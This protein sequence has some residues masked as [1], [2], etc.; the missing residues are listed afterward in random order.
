MMLRNGSWMLA[1]ATAFALACGD[2]ASNGN[3]TGNGNANGNGNGNGTGNGDAPVVGEGVATVT[4]DASFEVRGPAAWDRT[5]T[6]LTV[7]GTTYTVWS[8]VVDGEGEAELSVRLVQAYEGDAPRVPDDGTHQLGSSMQ[9]NGVSVTSAAGDFTSFA[10]GTVTVRKDETMSGWSVEVSATRSGPEALEVSAQVEAIPQRGLVRLT[11]NG[12]IAP[13]WDGSGLLNELEPEQGIFSLTFVDTVD[14]DLEVQIELGS[15]MSPYAPTPG[16][17]AAG[18][19]IVDTFRLDGTPVGRIEPS[20][21]ELVITE[22]GE[23]TLSGTFQLTAESEGNAY[24]ITG[25]F[26]RVRYET[27]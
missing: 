14:E 15:T 4:G 18:D 8:I 16:T 9:N 20:S 25:E 6:S 2:D 22:V 23:E 5:S 17:Y 11:L 26:T 12:E 7:S 13:L 24:D 27:I 1:A 19:A 10:E 21:A 3:G